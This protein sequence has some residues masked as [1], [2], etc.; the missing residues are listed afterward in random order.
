MPTIP[1]GAN[2]LDGV[3]SLRMHG[4]GN[5]QTLIVSSLQLDKQIV[6]QRLQASRGPT[7]P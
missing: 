7:R 5:R 4:L 3:G 6:K 2:A 1:Q